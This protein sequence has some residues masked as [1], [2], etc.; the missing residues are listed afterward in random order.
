MSLEMN[1]LLFDQ[2]VLRNY[3]YIKNDMQLNL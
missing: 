2:F 1:G 3:N